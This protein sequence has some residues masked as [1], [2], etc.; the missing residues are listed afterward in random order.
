MVTRAGPRCG[1]LARGDLST[2]VPHP[3]CCRNDSPG[4]AVLGPGP[5]PGL[6][7]TLHPRL[8]ARGPI[9]GLRSP[10]RPR[11][12]HGHPGLLVAAI[13]WGELRGGDSSP[14][15]GGRKGISLIDPARDGAVLPVLHLAAAHTIIS[16]AGEVV[17]TETVAEMLRRQVAT[18]GGA[19]RERRRAH[20]PLDWP[21]TR[22]AWRTWRFESCSATTSQSSSRFTA[23]PPTSTN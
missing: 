20:G 15:R 2:T 12:R 9:A 18:L 23:C 8:D 19:R 1:G 21:S 4:P 10:A 7:L 11:C 17:T 3:R 14:K 6:R 16:Y 5:H 13:S 22:P